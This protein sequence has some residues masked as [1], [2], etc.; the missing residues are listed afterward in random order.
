[1][2]Q[3]EKEQSE[4]SVRA[5]Q[6]VPLNELVQKLK[7]DK[8]TV[9]K[10]EKEFSKKE[11]NSFLRKGFLYGDTTKILFVNVKI[12]KYLQKL[13][14]KEKGTENFISFVSIFGHV[15]IIKKPK[16][17]E[18]M[19]LVDMQKVSDDYYLHDHLLVIN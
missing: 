6:S 16:F 19:V 8:E 17:K 10:L 14:E 7:K 11:F 2:K 4:K 15:N 13:L 1:M 12:Y 9:F 18:V 5:L 3:S